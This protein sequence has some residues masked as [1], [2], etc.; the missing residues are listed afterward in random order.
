MTM[1]NIFEDNTVDKDQIP[2]AEDPVAAVVDD[3]L[4]RKYH[5]DIGD[6]KTVK[7]TVTVEIIQ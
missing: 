5:G 7:V 2:I 3:V 4:E 6:D 1:A